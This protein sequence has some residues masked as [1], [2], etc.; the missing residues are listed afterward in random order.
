MIISSSENAPVARVA[1]PQVSAENAVRMK[2][3]LLTLIHQGAVNL[4]VDLGSVK[5]IDSSGIAAFLMILKRLGPRGD[6][7]FI[8][9]GSRVE[10]AFRITR[11]DRVF[12]IVPSLAEACELLGDSGLR[13]AA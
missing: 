5:S 6:L 10:Q 9:I 11:M 8:N 2:D 13:K 1:G 7:V 3:D 12:T 4:I